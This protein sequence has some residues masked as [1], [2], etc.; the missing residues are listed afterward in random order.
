MHL[1]GRI[2]SITLNFHWHHW[3]NLIKYI[4][5]MLAWITIIMTNLTFT[6]GISAALLK[7][8]SDSYQQRTTE[9]RCPL[10]HWGLRM[11]VFFNSIL[12]LAIS[13]VTFHFWWSLSFSDWNERF[14]TASPPW[15]LDHLCAHA[16][17]LEILPGT[18]LQQPSLSFC[19]CAIP[20]QLVL[21][22]VYSSIIHLKSN[23]YLTFCLLICLQL[24][25]DNLKSSVKSSIVGGLKEFAHRHI[26]K[27]NSQKL[28]MFHIVLTKHLKAA[29]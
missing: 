4:N 19:S 15:D 28:H 1:L 2:R 29:D 3:H 6:F 11:S 18:H 26:F 12:Y 8:N 10:K 27:C 7:S 20:I 13:L 21:K 17:K 5:T 9:N 22:T 16:L 24:H 23:P 25:R 14:H